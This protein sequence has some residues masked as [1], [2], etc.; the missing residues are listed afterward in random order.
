MISLAPDGRDGV[1]SLSGVLTFAP[2]SYGA[3][4]AVISALA[5][6][7]LAILGSERIA[8]VWPA[9]GV[10]VAVLLCSSPRSWPGVLVA[11]LLGIGAGGMLNGGVFLSSFGLGAFDIVEVT[12]SAIAIRTFFGVTPDLSRMRFVAVGGAAAIGSAAISAIG[13]G[14]VLGWLG[15]GH[16]LSAALM[17]VLANGLGQMTVAPIVIALQNR[18]GLR[19]ISRAKLTWG[20]VGVAALAAITAA[21]FWQSRYDLLYVVLAPLLLV[22]FQLEVLGAAIG[23]LVISMLSVAFT[24]RGYGPLWSINASDTER[25][26]LL[27]VFILGVAAM[28]FPLA[29]ALADRR[30]THRSARLSEAR[31][32][33]LS[34]HSRDVVMR[35]APDRSIIDVSASARRYGYEPES[36]INA[37]VAIHTHPD[38]LPPLHHLFNQLMLDRGISQS[39]MQEWRIRRASGEWVWMEGSVTCVRD[40]QDEVSEFVLV[41]RDISERRAAAEAIAL[42][43]AR[44]RLLAENSQDI[45]FEFDD[46]SRILYA[47]AAIRLLGYAPQD[48]IGRSCFSF[49]HPD[50]VAV[51]QRAM[52]ATIHPPLDGEVVSR[53]WRLRAASG[54]YIWF[55]GNPSVSRDPAGRP[56]R[57]SDSVRD[58]SRR[59]ALEDE[60][61]RKQAEADA[62][63]QARRAAE[64]RARENQDELARV[65]RVLSVGEF[66]STIAH[67][68]NQP[69]AAIVTNG[70][71]ALRWLAAEPPVLDEARAAVARSIRDANRA[72]AVVSRTRAMLAKGSP[73]FAEVDINACIHDVLLFSDTALRRNRITI[74]RR[75]GGA[76][77]KVWGDRVQSDRQRHGR[78]GGKRGAPA[79]AC[80]NHRCGR[81]RRRAGRS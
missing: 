21:T 8:P 27:Q 60:L 2:W 10:L 22:V 76:L 52:A 16:V 44:Y 74:I 73:A 53:E 75:L 71:T 33:F 26:I 17:W 15:R 19:R 77:P 72:A 29:A 67:E 5:W 39:E 32:V 55:E 48:V 80:D 61:R 47:S 50:D 65:S 59:K 18:E 11:G 58:I 42:S 54:D 63:E 78:D 24:V 43:E 56:V 9:N 81:R 46:K 7:S 4:A 23:I 64:A 51:V 40:A 38:D 14:A 20:V 6:L 41:I 30:R 62:S 12:L 35:I 57:F 79:N 68:L 28:N 37:W 25:V 36:L 1:P 45:V 34:E 70:D 31:L 66:A 3:L 49:V 13:A 69:I